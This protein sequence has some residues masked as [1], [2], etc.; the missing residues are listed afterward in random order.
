MPNHLFLWICYNGRNTDYFQMHKQRAPLSFV[1]LSSLYESVLVRIFQVFQ[2]PL[3][4]IN[5]FHFAEYEYFFFLLGSLERLIYY[6]G[7]CRYSHYL[8]RRPAIWPPADSAEVQV[9]GEL[10][11]DPAYLAYS[12]VCKCESQRSEM[13]MWINFICKLEELICSKV[14]YK[15]SRRLQ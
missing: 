12:L 7:G 10:C 9:L 3:S 11:T 8:S 14:W 5:S 6:S 1:G 2:M 13:M 4:M 15:P